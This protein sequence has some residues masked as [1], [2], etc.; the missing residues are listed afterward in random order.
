MKNIIHLND[1]TIIK[2]GRNIL[3]GKLL[4]LLGKG[5]LFCHA[6]ILSEKC[7][8]SWHSLHSHITTCIIPAN[9]LDNRCNPEECWNMVICLHGNI[10]C[11]AGG[12]G[13]ESGSRGLSN[14]ACPKYLFFLEPLPLRNSSQQPRPYLRPPF[15]STCVCTVYESE[16]H[17]PKTC[18]FIHALLQSII[19]LSKLSW[20][21][22]CAWLHCREYN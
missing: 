2:A 22:P 6:I 10:P 8:L 14:P 1:I 4:A 12:K 16:I 19:N 17:L 9:P 7:T 18:L 11:R 20:L 15:V 21:L 5:R 13:L 3:F